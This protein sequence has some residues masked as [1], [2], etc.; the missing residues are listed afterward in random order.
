[1]V[2]NPKFQKKGVRFLPVLFIFIEISPIAVFIAG[3]DNERNQRQKQS[4]PSQC[5]GRSLHQVLPLPPPQD[6]GYSPA[7]GGRRPLALT[8]RRRRRWRSLNMYLWRRISV[9]I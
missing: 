7:A 5:Q 2:L 9:E 3:H 4:D 6:S 8:G 1:M